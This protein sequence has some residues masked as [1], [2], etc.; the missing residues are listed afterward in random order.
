MLRQLKLC[1]FNLIVTN[2]NYIGIS[3]WSRVVEL[4]KIQDRKVYTVNPKINAW[5]V[6]LIFGIFRGAFIRGRR[7]FKS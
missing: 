1:Y 6:Y 7:L 3:S 4:R 2:R 5:G